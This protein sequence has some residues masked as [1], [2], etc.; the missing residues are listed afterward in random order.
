LEESHR[1]YKEAFD[2]LSQRTAK[3]KEEEETLLIDLLNEWA[4]ALAYKGAFS[5]LIE[6]F[7]AHEGLAESIHDKER[8]GMFYGGLGVA[9]CMREEFTESYTYL[10]KSLELG[11]QTKS[12]KVTGHACFRLALTCANLGYLDEAV[13]HGERARDLSA[14]PRADLPLHLVAFGLLIAY[15]SRGDI[16]KL[17]ELGTELLDEGRKGSDPRCLATGEIDLGLSHSSAG[18]FLAAIED[19]KAALQASIDRGKL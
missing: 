2:L 11:E 1:F 5:E 17:R 16:R 9:L 13:K 6:L 12:P 4:F 7:K 10:R 19:F 18:D 15:W 3:N 8:L 14:D